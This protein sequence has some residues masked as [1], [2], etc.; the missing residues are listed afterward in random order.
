MLEKFAITIKEFINNQLT[1]T[2]HLEVARDCLEWNLF[3]SM[4]IGKL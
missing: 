1:A 3:E 4:L 2:I